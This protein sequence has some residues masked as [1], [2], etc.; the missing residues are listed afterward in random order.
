MNY[1]DPYILHRNNV[2]QPFFVHF[3]FHFKLLRVKFLYNK[4]SIKAVI[5]IKSKSN[6]SNVHTAGFAV[7]VVQNNIVVTVFINIYLTMYII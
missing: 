2:R 5:P 4:P 1:A 3:P 6:T 7:Y